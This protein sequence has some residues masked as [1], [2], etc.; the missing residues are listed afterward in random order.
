[1]ARFEISKKVV[2]IN[3]ASSA[4]VLILNLSVLIWL[5]QYL[6]KRISPEEF[7][8]IP[9]LMSIM[10]FVPLVTMVLT[11]GI[12]RYI[13]IAYAKEDD[14]EIERICSTMFPILCVAGL[15]F[16][17]V[18]CVV[19]WHIDTLLN[20]APN[21]VSDAQLMFMLLIFSAALRIPLAVF[22]SGFFVR[23]KFLL[24]DMIGIGCQLLRYTILFSLFFGESTR[25]LWVVVAMVV[26]EVVNLLIS[27]VVSLRLVPAQRIRWKVFHRRIATEVTEYGGWSFINRVA[28]TIRQAFDP[29]ILNRFATAVDVSVFHVGGIAPR[30]LQL[31]LAP[32]TRPLLPIL[33]GL[34]ATGDFVKLSNTYLRSA[35]YHSWV[36]LAAAVP[37]II[38]SDEVIHIYLDGKYEDA[39]VVMAVLLGVTVL[40]GFNALGPAAVAAAGKMKEMSL[41]LI[42]VHTV[43]IMLTVALVVYL[44]KG[45]IGSALAT[46][47][48]VVFLEATF[49]WSF[50]RRVTQTPT[51]LWVKDVVLPCL[52]P[53]LPPV[54]MCV[55]AKNMIVVDT[56]VELLL[57]SVF[58]V[59]LHF[60]LVGFFGLRQQDRIDLGRLAERLNG[61]LKKIV[62]FFG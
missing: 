11:D 35:R 34:Y 58:S 5:Q 44:Q 41:R 31:M 42:A 12:G 10:I 20:I 37:A 22:G 52:G 48:T 7:S 4:A 40:N 13:T 3:S 26:G 14:G 30:Q 61:P 46:L 36:I 15:A 60:V 59:T 2:L 6:L 55:A 50:C 62:Q 43:N 57:V 53:A 45:A 23:Q 38:F 25:V 24:Q 1:M 16:F 21:F 56:L 39:G 33:T 29:L 47:V 51:S 17:F 54:L 32:L 9:V 8:L 18:G 27:S 19:A 28:E 49:I